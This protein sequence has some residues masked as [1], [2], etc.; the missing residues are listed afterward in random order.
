MVGWWVRWK[1]AR[2]VWKDLQGLGLDRLESKECGQCQRSPEQSAVSRITSHDA[3]QNGIRV[4]E[5]FDIR[6]S[7]DLLFVCRIRRCSP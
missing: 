1:P 2:V 3:A 5:M 4:N 6:C 7:E